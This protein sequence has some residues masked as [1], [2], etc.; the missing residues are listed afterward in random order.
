MRS[1]TDYYDTPDRVIDRSPLACDVAPFR[2]E[3]CVNPRKAP[4]IHSVV[5][6]SSIVR[7]RKLP[8][9]ENSRSSELSKSSELSRSQVSIV[10]TTEE[11]QRRIS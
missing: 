5:E 9:R 8:R 6:P 7:G 1:R 2:G 3:T 4:G 10:A 11:N